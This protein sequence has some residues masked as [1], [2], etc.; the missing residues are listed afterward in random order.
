[1]FDAETILKGRDAVLNRL[2]ELN[3]A[4]NSISAKE[5]NQKTILEVAK[6]M[7]ARGYSFLPP[8]LGDSDATKFRIKDG[9]VLLPFVAI[10]GCGESAAKGLVREYDIRPYLTIEEAQKRGGLNKSVVEVLKQY[11][12]FEGMTETDQITMF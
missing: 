6:E 3:E 8:K 5:D 10:A 4:G 11:G 1:D 7:Y 2:K 9:K 12:V